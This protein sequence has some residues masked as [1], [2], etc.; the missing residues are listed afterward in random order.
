M[1]EP[2]RID[3]ANLRRWLHRIEEACATLGASKEM[4]EVREAALSALA[5]KPAPTG[6]GLN[7]GKHV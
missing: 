5:G 7:G 6:P 3:P 4:I 1:D 2:A